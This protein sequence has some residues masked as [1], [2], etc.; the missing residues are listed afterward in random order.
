MVERKVYYPSVVTEKR[1][2]Y[3]R[4]SVTGAVF[5]PMFESLLYYHFSSIPFHIN[6]FRPE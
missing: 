2:E 5:A 1:L 3:I 6:N 4:V